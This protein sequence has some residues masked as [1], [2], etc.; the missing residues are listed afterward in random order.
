MHVYKDFAKNCAMNRQ[1]TVKN[2]YILANQIIIINFNL[3]NLAEDI[4]LI[5]II[6]IWIYI[7]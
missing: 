4:I 6:N 3:K 2:K 5:R 1:N 7:I